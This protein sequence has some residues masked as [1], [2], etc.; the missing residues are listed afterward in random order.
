MLLEQASAEMEGLASDESA[1]LPMIEDLLA[2]YENYPGGRDP[3]G[4]D[5]VRKAR[6]RLKT[7]AAVNV[8]KIR[9]DLRDVLKSEDFKAVQE[10]LREYAKQESPQIKGVVA[11]L[12]ARQDYLVVDFVRQLTNSLSEEDPRK[13]DVL[14]VKVPDYQDMPGVKAAVQA[15]KDR[16]STA[17]RTVRQEI[18]RNSRN[19]NFKAV[20]D[21]V[22][23]YEGYPEDT[24]VEFD[25]LVAHR[26][27]ILDKA[28]VSLKELLESTDP[29]FISY[30]LSKYEAYGDL[31]GMELDEVAERKR[32]LISNAVQELET[33]L[34]DEAT[35]IALISEKLVQFGSYP[36]IDRMR[37]KL[38]AKLDEQLASG[39]KEII[40][41][42]ESDDYQLVMDTLTKHESSGEHLD[43]N[44][45][46]LE[47]HRER[48]EEKLA[49]KLQDSLRV[50]D[51]GKVRALLDQVAALKENASFSTLVAEVQ[52]HFDDLR[53]GVMSKIEAALASEEPAGIDVLL[54]DADR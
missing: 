25:I 14:L 12:Q 24:R 3:A 27:Q 38:T 33:L 8:A 52:A 48:L 10:K 22:S 46:A 21:A 13:I 42:M 50:M 19:D 6:D 45:R 7:Q 31:V 29:G 23:Q 54:E 37:V 11:D 36:E 28:K 20:C 43:S 15:L 34:S 4:T 9:S 18:K 49:S 30:E 16:R 35:T 53:Q 5:G 2:K 41:A 44:L 17:I 26:D 40:V 39:K 1:T 47:N 51:M 32:E